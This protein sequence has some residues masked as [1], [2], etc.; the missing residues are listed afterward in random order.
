MPRLEDFLLDSSRRRAEH[1]ALVQGAEALTYRDLVARA[2]SVAGALASRGV[3][4]GDRVVLCGGNSIDM[5]V[6]FWATLLAGAVVVPVGAHT[7]RERLHWLLSHCS[8]AALV[9]EPAVAAL[10]DPDTR[11]ALRTVVLLG[12]QNRSVGA[13][14]HEGPAAAADADLAAILYTS[15]STGLP[16]GVMLTHVNMV[17]AAESIATYLGLEEADVVQVLSPLSFDYGLY[18][19][20]LSARVGARCVLAPSFMLP[21][22]VLKQAAA[23]RVTV[24]PGVPTQFAM[25]GALR[26]V[27]RWDLSSVR[28]VTSTAATL[29]RAHIATIER[30][31]PDARIFSMYGLTECKRCTYLPPDDLTRKPDSVG[32]AIPGTELWVVDEHDRRVGP[33]QVGQLVIRGPHVMQG[34]W[35]DPQETAQKLRPGPL[36]GEQVLYTGDLCRLDEEGFLYFVGRTDDIIKVRGEKVAPREVE[37]ALQA[38]PGVREAAVVGVPDELLGQAIKAFVVVA[39]GHSLTPADILQGCRE[40]LE[41][42]MVPT[43]VNL[44]ASLPQTPHGKID[45]LRLAAAQP[46]GDPAMV[47]GPIS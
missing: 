38:I 2:R 16:K 4:R 25:L 17:S 44:V 27:S 14:Q 46:F 10:L 33:A 1:I 39:E 19:A 29:T 45:K 11:G 34:Y 21:G 23:E 22:Q 12:E 30:L 7:K 40:R 47:L 3:G 37:L 6:G 8:A 41:P 20:I 28:A 15:G 9:A 43:H 35:R 24:F 13:V 31:F 32:I 36:P 5:L 18:Q 26:D 42:L